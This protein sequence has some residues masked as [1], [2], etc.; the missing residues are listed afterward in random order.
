MYKILTLYIVV[1]R[2]IPSRAV[3]R[4]GKAPKTKISHLHSTGAPHLIKS[5]D[6]R[7]LPYYKVG[8][9]QYVSRVV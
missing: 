6:T 5:T 3:P 4:S 2:A 1:S 9:K 7:L 8:G